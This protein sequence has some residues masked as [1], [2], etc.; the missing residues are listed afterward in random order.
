MRVVWTGRVEQGVSGKD[1]GG[2][3]ARGFCGLGREGGSC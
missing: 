3:T 1:D 2:E